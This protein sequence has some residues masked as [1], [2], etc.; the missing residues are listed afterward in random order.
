MAT[1]TGTS[2]CAPSGTLPEPTVKTAGTSATPGGVP[3]GASLEQ[4]IYF[5]GRFLK[6]ED[7][8]L[9]QQSTLTRIALSERAQGAGVSYGFHVVP[10][11][12]ALPA[13]YVNNVASTVY[14]RML[15]RKSEWTDV[16]KDGTD[17]LDDERRKR[18]ADAIHEVCEQ[19]P[20]GGG[21]VCFLIGPGHGADGYGHD[22][23]SKSEQKVRLSALIDDF[24][25]APVSCSF[26]GPAVSP[27]TIVG[28]APPLT[29]AFLLTVLLHENDHGKVPVY[30]VQCSDN[31]DSACSFGYRATG[32]ALKLV[33]FSALEGAVTGGDPYFWRGAG[34]RAYTTRETQVRGSRLADMSASLP[35]SAGAAAPETGTH[36][37]IGIVYLQNGN[38]VSFDEWAAKRLREPGEAAYWLRSLTHPPRNSQLARVLQFEAQVTESLAYARPNRSLSLWKNG[39]ADGETLVLPGV[40]FLPVDSKGRKGAV[41]EAFLTKYM[42]A[43]F[44]GVPFKLMPTNPGELNAVFVGALES[45]ELRLTR[46]SAPLDDEDSGKLK[47]IGEILKKYQASEITRSIDVARSQAL[48]MQLETASPIARELLDLIRLPI[49]IKDPLAHELPAQVLVW[50][51]ADAFPGWVMFTWPSK[52]LVTQVQERI[53]LC[54]STEFRIDQR[55]SEKAAFYDPSEPP[56]GRRFREGEPAGPPSTDPIQNNFYRL[57]GFKIEIE[58]EVEGLG[59]EFSA[60]VDTEEGLHYEQFPE[61][62]GFCRLRQDQRQELEFSGLRVRLTGALKERYDV[63]YR[64]IFILYYYWRGGR[65]LRNLEASG[66]PAALLAKVK[67]AAELSSS[68]EISA[69]SIGNEWS[70]YAESMV[71]QN[72]EL[73]DVNLVL[74]GNFYSYY[75]VGAKLHR[76]VVEIVP[77]GCTTHYQPTG[78]SG[79]TGPTGPIGDDPQYGRGKVVLGQE[80]AASVAAKGPIGLSGASVMV[81][82]DLLVQKKAVSPPPEAPRP[83]RKKH[84]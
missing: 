67:A 46:P 19:E 34:V 58:P 7:L 10:F 23:Y 68:D 49:T 35:F 5:N 78:A 38:F 26:P 13:S 52:T 76:F 64:G 70:S 48:T 15:K 80:I 2:N 1:K 37:P 21:D 16:F 27:T 20:S 36:V 4:L 82:P 14:E 8:G 66:M 45:P 30:G 83:S 62:D 31:L 75:L 40:G 72:G 25:K 53:P 69:A 74:P 55:N 17:G 59:L 81:T 12:Q 60:K 63:R 65:D 56:L 18:L 3:V 29:G 28:G 41:T 71:A 73:C 6:A 32:L 9:E 79:P 77:K 84:T 61:D 42:N 57:D 22:L 11:Q 47:Q 44:E 51:L 33:H 24:V 54:V 43:Y 39:F 50:Y